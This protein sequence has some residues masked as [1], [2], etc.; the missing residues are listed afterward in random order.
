M[1]IYCSGTGG[2]LGA[3]YAYT[4]IYIHT[5]TQSSCKLDKGIKFNLYPLC[6]YLTAIP[7]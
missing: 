7:L 4:Y 2:L 1:L 6:N 5:Y 3:L